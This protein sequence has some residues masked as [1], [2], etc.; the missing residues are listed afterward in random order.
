MVRTSAFQAEN[1]GSTPRG[2]TP[3]KVLLN[4]TFTFPAP[5]SAYVCGRVMNTRTVTAFAL[6]AGTAIGI[7]LAAI[8]V[9]LL[10]MLLGA[11]A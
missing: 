5:R 8:A 11:N 3:P 9:A 4:K 10:A 7:T 1:R 2:A 6:A